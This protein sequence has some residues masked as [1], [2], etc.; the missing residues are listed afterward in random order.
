MKRQAARTGNKV[1]RRLS[2]EMVNILV[3]RDELRHIA[4]IE[5]MARPF[6]SMA[7]RQEYVQKK[8]LAEEGSLK[9][10]EKE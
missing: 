9:Y 7:R 2:G 8:R 5:A 4:D 1:V 3:D 6:N 10:P